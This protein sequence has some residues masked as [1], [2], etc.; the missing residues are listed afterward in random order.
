MKARG[1]TLIE[2]VVAITIS[3]IV[4]VFAAMFIG[5]PLGAYETHSRRAALIADTSGA[6]P[7][8]ETDLRAALPNSLRARRNG[9]YVAMEMLTVL[10]VGRYKV[11]PST[12]TFDTGGVYRGIGVPR[13]LSV[14]NLG[15]AA[16]N[17]YAFSG[18][19]TSAATTLGV[20][21][22]LATGENH[23]SANPAPAFTTDS[24]KQRIYFVEGPVTYLCDETLGTLRRYANYPVAANQT[25]YDT[26][27]KFTAVGAVGE[28]VTSGLTSC[29]FETSPMDST[30][31]S[32]ATQ[33]AAVRLTT[34]RNGDTV[35]LLH[36]VHGEYAP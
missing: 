3:A 7:R 5:A 12:S 13:Y 8:M 26:P 30:A 22:D 14:N 34:M 24:L 17:A 18:S 10:D 31:R 23:V 15:T 33:T 29:N 32:T 35:T 9:A 19:M 4:V 1:F 16:A 20:V 21:P 25:S 11:L 2:L 27:A 28:L 6:W 36:S